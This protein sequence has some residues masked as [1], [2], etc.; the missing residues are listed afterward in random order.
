MIHSLTIILTHKKSKLE[1]IMKQI[2][3][4]IV[5]FSKASKLYELWANHHFKLIWAYS[6]LHGS[7]KMQKKCIT[8]NTVKRKYSQQ[9]V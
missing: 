1:K 9:K 6:V 2:D 3:Q 4:F 7:N 8:H 5:L